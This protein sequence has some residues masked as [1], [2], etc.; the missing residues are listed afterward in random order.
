MI[1]LIRT[2]SYNSDFIELVKLLDVDLVV[3]DGDDHAFYDQFNKLD[4]IK[5]TVVAYENNIAA[6]CGAMKLYDSATMEIKRMYT[7]LAYRGKGIAG[8]VLTELENWATELSYEKCI[9]ETGIRQPEAIALYKK[10][11]YQII[12]NYGQYSGM[13]TSVCFEK[14]LMIAPAKNI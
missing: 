2:N 14:K 8:K 6:G 11:G 12:A 9:L 5:N 10:H 4:N 1:Q 3:R 13:E 7:S